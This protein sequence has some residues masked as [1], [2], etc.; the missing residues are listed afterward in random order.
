MKLTKQGVRDLNPPG[1]NNP[2]KD[3]RCR[4]KW[5]PRVFLRIMY[6]SYF[7]D[8]HIYGRRCLFCPESLEDDSFMRLK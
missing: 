8:I 1:H 5:G 3:R 2:S 7:G 6:D 4:H